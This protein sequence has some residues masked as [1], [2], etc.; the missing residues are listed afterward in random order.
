MEKVKFNVAIQ[1]YME[2]FDY[3]INNDLFI[4]DSGKDFLKSRIKIG[5][6]GFVLETQVARNTWDEENP[7]EKLV[8]AIYVL[9]IL[10]KNI[11]EILRTMN[12]PVSPSK[13]YAYI[14]DA[15]TKLSGKKTYYK[16]Y[17][18]L[19][20]LLKQVKQGQ[21]QLQYSDGKIIDFNLTKLKSLSSVFSKLN[22]LEIR[23]IEC[24]ARL[25]EE[26][27]GYTIN[28]LMI[29][30]N[31]YPVDDFRKH[32][33]F[34]ND[35][36]YPLN[37]ASKESYVVWNDFKNCITDNYEYQLEENKFDMNGV[38]SPWDENPYKSELGLDGKTK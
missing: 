36:S 4:F 2:V 26:L 32:F 29:D 23:T 22:P 16:S 8:P 35:S 12:V 5:D 7:N 19:L 24:Y 13:D 14:N 28:L 21:E 10:T 27:I 37:F 15:K 25:E 33:Y 18:D 17:Q 9:N 3:L 20:Q 11:D 34:G 1:T 31:G 30:E 38:Y 6:Y